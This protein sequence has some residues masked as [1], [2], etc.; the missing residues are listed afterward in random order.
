MSRI[1]YLLRHAK[2]S[3]NSPAAR[4]LDRPLASRGEKAAHLMGNWMQAQGILPRLTISSP[5]RRAQQTAEIVTTQLALP[6]DTISYDAR[7]Y[8]ADSET[9]LEVLKEWANK[10]NEMMLV[11]HN[12]GLDDLLIGLCGDDLPLSN[13]GKLMTTA[14]L[15]IIR[16]HGNSGQL[17]NIIR[18]KEIQ[19]DSPGSFSV[20]PH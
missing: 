14:T 4:D 3:W 16:L 8:M 6:R 7:I 9:L 18:P 20:R 19:R 10:Q 1:L 13:S 17:I 12:P 2:S 5:A 11:G 15:A